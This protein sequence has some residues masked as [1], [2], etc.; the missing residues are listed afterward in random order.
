[1][2]VISTFN[3]SLL[4]RGEDSFSVPPLTGTTAIAAVQQDAFEIEE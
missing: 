4:K 1:M 2:V 3:E